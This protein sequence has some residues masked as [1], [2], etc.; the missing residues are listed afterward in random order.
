MKSYWPTYYLVFA[1][2]KFILL[3]YFR[4]NLTNPMDPPLRLHH[5]YYVK[6]APAKV[7]LASFNPFMAQ[8]VKVNPIKVKRFKLERMS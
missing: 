5:K 4:L 3:E 8:L 1:N 7:L 6:N 2:I